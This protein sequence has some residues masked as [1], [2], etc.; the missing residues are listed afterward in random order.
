MSEGSPQHWY[1]PPL[2]R[3]TTVAALRVIHADAAE[4]HEDGSP[5]GLTLTEVAHR[6]AVSRASSEDAVNELIER[7]L[8]AEIV[9][10]PDAP[11]PVGRPAKRYRFRAEYG[12]VIGVDIGIHKVLALCTDL[13]GTIRGSHRIEVSAEH[14]N[15][16]RVQAAR[17][18][19]KR[20]A[21]AASVRLADVLAVGVGTTGP[22]HPNTGTIA[23]SPALPEWSGVD[24]QSRQDHHRRRPVPSRRHAPQTPQTPARRAVPVPHP[25]PSLTPRRTERRAGRRPPSPRPPRSPALHQPVNWQYPVVRRAAARAGSGP[26]VVPAGQGLPRSPGSRAPAGRRRRR[27][28][29][30]WRTSH[31]KR[32]GTAIAV[33]SPG[34]S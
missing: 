18:A 21:R 2:S 10:D 5:G 24:I 20:A 23:L 22:V 34:W 33:P 19:L 17:T 11:R 1:G 7:E 28:A 26:A 30:A 4:P 25:R 27:S 16:E 3:P 14:G 6:A 13:V 12:A 31:G 32:S 15:A 8:L 29:T 9:P